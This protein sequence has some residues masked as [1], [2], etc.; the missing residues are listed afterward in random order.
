[1]T[2]LIASKERCI[3]IPS[4]QFALHDSDGMQATSGRRTKL[5]RESQV[6]GKA[7]FLPSKKAEDCFHIVLRLGECPILSRN[8][9]IKIHVTFPL[10]FVVKKIE[11]IIT[12][13]V[14]KN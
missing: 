8:D 12:N 3:F 5:T 14:K 11:G 1:M 7:R 9:G 10:F 6:D 4:P 2:S 13:Q